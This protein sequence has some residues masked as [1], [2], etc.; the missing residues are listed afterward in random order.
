[1][2]IS[3][4]YTITNI[5]TYCLN[6]LDIKYINSD[7]ALV[8]QTTLPHTNNDNRMF[9]N[10]SLLC[11]V[12]SFWIGNNHIKVAT[13]LKLVEKI[14]YPWKRIF[15]LDGHLVQHM[16]SI[17]FLLNKQNLINHWGYTWPNETLRPC[18]ID[19]Y[20]ALISL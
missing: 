7:G 16:K 10:P 8:N 17:I 19:N 20:F 1:M 2:N 12:S 6:T 3:S 9:S 4:M 13:S 5:S 15:F 18:S 14:I 11:Y